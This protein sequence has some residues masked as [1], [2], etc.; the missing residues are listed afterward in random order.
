MHPVN[1]TQILLKIVDSSCRGVNAGDDWVTRACFIYRCWSL[2][3]FTYDL[4]Y[5]FYLSTCQKYNVKVPILISSGNQKT[6]LCDADVKSW[7]RCSV[8]LRLWRVSALRRSSQSFL[9]SML[10]F[11]SMKTWRPRWLAE[12]ITRVSEQV[13]W[14]VSV[15][16]FCF[17]PWYINCL[18]IKS[19]KCK[20]L[21]KIIKQRNY[22]SCWWEEM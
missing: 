20:K 19:K 11:Y 8:T 5:L 13:S 6:I 18:F 14:F 16:L 15:N 22:N 7:N 12:E 3:S 17:S 10:T 2:L 4:W 9:L 21:I 1:S